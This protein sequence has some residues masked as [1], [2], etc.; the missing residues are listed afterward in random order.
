[1]NS[2]ACP[3]IHRTL[4]EEEK[5]NKSDEMQKKAQ[6]YTCTVTN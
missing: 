5:K 2:M 4:Q 6:R 3:Q 1:M